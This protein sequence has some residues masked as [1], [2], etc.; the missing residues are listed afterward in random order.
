MSIGMI[1]AAILT[2]AVAFVV[3]AA[4]LALVKE[5]FF[6]DASYKVRAEALEHE[7]DIV[8]QQRYAEHMGTIDGM[9]CS[10]QESLDELEKLRQKTL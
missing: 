9:K 5:A 1:A 4:G 7:L 8:R 6:S 2:F 10:T 3:F